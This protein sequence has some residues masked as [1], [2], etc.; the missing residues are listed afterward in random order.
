[1]MRIAAALLALTSTAVVAQPHPT[2]AAKP[3]DKGANTVVCK[4]FIRTGSLV[5][6]YRECK[7]KADWQ[8]ER[9]AVRAPSSSIDSC[10]RSDSA[11]GC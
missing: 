4:R 3:T 6:G 11:I 9:N 7:S 1:M 2:P 8:R 5:D 10:R